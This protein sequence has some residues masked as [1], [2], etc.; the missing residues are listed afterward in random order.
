[1]KIMHTFESGC[2]VPGPRGCLSG[3]LLAGLIATASG[4][5]SQPAAN[6]PGGGASPVIAS[7]TNGLRLNFRGV[8]L[9]M[10]LDYL[11]SVR[12]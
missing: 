1:M 6:A 11:T 7:G 12:N 2:A 5:A 3:A 10:V 4:L 9:E 8:P